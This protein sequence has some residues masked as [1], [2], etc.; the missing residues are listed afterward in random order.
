MRTFSHV[1]LVF[2]LFV[3]GAQGSWFQAPGPTERIPN[4]EFANY[5]PRWLGWTNPYVHY[6]IPAGESV[7]RQ[8]AFGC[9]GISVDVDSRGVVHMV[10]TTQIAM[11][12]EYPLTIPE[13]KNFH[14]AYKNTHH[15]SAV[16]GGVGAYTDLES[17]WATLTSNSEDEL[18][19][20]ADLCVDS[21]DRIH[22]VWV[23]SFRVSG[24]VGGSDSY[25]NYQIRYMRRD[26]NGWSSKVILTAGDV[27]ATKVT[28]A[29]PRIKV[30]T[31]GV[32]RVIAERQDMNIAEDTQ[33]IRLRSCSL[34]YIEYSGG[35]SLT[36]V[37]P[38]DRR[39]G[40]ANGE[41]RLALTSNNRPYVVWT[42][43]YR[44]PKFENSTEYVDFTQVY[45]AVLSGGG[46][47]QKVAL[48]A[49]V[50]A[51]G[52]SNFGAYVTVGPGDIPYFVYTRYSKPGD[53]SFLMYQKGEGF[54]QEALSPSVPSPLFG[55]G[56]VVV[57]SRN[58]PHVLW[59]EAEILM[60]KAQVKN[61]NPAL[62]SVWR[63][64]RPATGSPV[65]FK[66]PDQHI[67][68]VAISRNDEMHVAGRRYY[69]RTMEYG[70][71]DREDEVMTRAFPGGQVNLSSGNLFYELP[72]FST[73]GFGPS[74]NLSLIYNSLETQTSS[75]SPGWRFNL[76]V[77]LVDNWI[78]END[79]SILSAA[80]GPN[81]MITVFFGDGRPVQFRFKSFDPATATLRYLVADDEYGYFGKLE[82]TGFGNVLKEYKLTTKH[83]DIL[84][85]NW[86]GRLGRIEDA[87]GNYMDITYE[88]FSDDAGNSWYRMKQIDDQLGNG[89]GGRG[90]T[91]IEYESWTNALYPARPVRVI[92]P[93]GRTIKLNYIGAQLTSV[94]FDTVE[95]K[96][97]Y[98]FEYCTVDDP[99]TGQR[100]GQLRRF[101]PPRGSGS[102]G[103]T[104][105]YLPDGR[106]NKIEDPSEVLVTDGLADTAPPSAMIASMLVEYEETQPEFAPRR[107]FHTDRRG[108]KT[109]YTVEPRRSLTWKIEEPNP[110]FVTFRSF[111][112]YANLVQVTDRLGAVTKYTYQ[113]T[114]A[115]YP[116]V[117][118]NLLKIERQ[119][120]FA[121]GTEEV[122]N[123]TYTMD[124]FN[125]V[126]T[127]TTIS[128]NP[129]GGAATPRTSTHLYNGVGQRIHTDHPN[130][131]LPN[132]QSQSASTDYVYDGPRKQ[133][134]RI[135]N[136]EGHSTEFSEFDPSCGFPGS[137]LQEGGSEARKRGYDSL[138]N[139]FFMTEPRGG[140]KN[141]TP[142]S[143][144][145]VRDFKDRI[146]QV[147]D[148]S[149][150]ITKYQYD[151]DSNLVLEIPP[152]GGP[153]STTYDKRGYVSGGTNPDG[154][155]SEWVDAEGNPRRFRNL[156][157]FETNTDRDYLD[158]VTETRIPGGSTVSGGAGGGPAIHKVQYAHDLIQAGGHS[159]TVTMVGSPANRTS[160]TVYDRRG[161]QVAEIEAD[162]STQSQFFHNQQD[163]VIAQQIVAGGV[164]QECTAYFRD[165][166]DRIDH[167]R[168]QEGPYGGTI[169]QASH[170]YFIHNRCGSVL[171]EVDPLGSV[172]GASQ[173]HRTTHVYDARERA[174][175][176]IDG[177]GVIVRE[178]TYGDDD[179]VTREAGPDPATKGTELVTIAEYSY[180]PRK[181]VR[182]VQNRDGKG[183][184]YGYG[185][186][187]GQITVEIDPLGRGKTTVYDSF[188]QHVSEVI[189][190]DGT[191]DAQR[192]LYSWS[193]GLLVETR[194]W[195][196]VTHGF[197]VIHR[198]YYD[199]SNRL[200]REE[201]PGQAP[202]DF[203]YNDF[204]DVKDFKAGAKAVH[205]TY[206]DL[207]QAVQSNWS[208]AY[209]VQETRTFN[210]QGHLGSKSDGSRQRTMQYDTWKGTPAVETFAVGGSTWK[211]QT[212]NV[213]AAGN[214]TALTNPEGVAHTWPVDENNRPKEKRVGANASAL[215]TY[216]PGGLPD[217]TFLS[218]PTG[219]AVATTTFS[220]D[221]IG[222]KI[223]AFTTKA[224]TNEVVADYRWEYND[225]DEVVKTDYAHLGAGFD[226]TRDG[227]GRV[228]VEVTPGNGGGLTPPPYSNVLGGDPTGTAGPPSE[229]SRAVPKTVLPVPAR[230][231]VVQY[232]AAGNRSDET[233][234]GVTT[235]FTYNDAGQ[236]IKEISTGKTVD[237][238]YDD[239]GN[240]TVKRTTVGQNTTTEAYGYDPHGR[241]S[242]YTNSATGQA[243]QYDNWPTGERYAKTDLNTSQKSLQ[244]PRF[245][246]P[247]TDYSQTG[248]GPIS[249][250]N[251]YLQDSI[252]EDRAGRVPASGEAM[253]YLEGVEESITATVGSLGSTSEKVQDSYGETVAG[254]LGEPLGAAGWQDEPEIGATL[255]PDGALY[256]PERGVF[257]NNP[258][259]YAVKIADEMYELQAK[260]KREQYYS[261]KKQM[262]DA[263]W[264][265]GEAPECFIKIKEM[266]GWS[267]EDLSHTLDDMVANAVK[268]YAI[269][270][271][272]MVNPAAAIYKAVAGEDTRGNKLDWRERVLA[273]LDAVG[274][275]A[276]V[277][278]GASGLRSAFNTAKVAKGAKTAQ[279]ARGI[280]KN[281]SKAESLIAQCTKDCF[282]AGTQVVTETGLRNIEDIRPGDLVLSRNE[283]TGDLDYRPVRRTFV[284][285]ADTLYHVSYLLLQGTPSSHGLTA[286]SQTAS[287]HT[288]VCTSE[289][290]FWQAAESD[291]VPASQLM[292]GDILATPGASARIIAIRQERAPPGTE[293]TTFN[294]EVEGEH[295][296]FVT[297]D[298]A[299]DGNSAV[300]VHN[301]CKNRMGSNIP[302]V[303][304]AAARG[305]TFHAD[306]PGHLPDQIRGKYDATQFE[307]KPPGQPGQDV[308]VVGGKHPS[309]YPGSSWPKDKK[310][311]DFKP[312]TP[313]G[314]KTF[315]YDQK[316]K[317]KEPTHM[318]PYD[319]KTGKLVDE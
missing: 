198:R 134:T 253:H 99:A 273:G 51:L 174:I 111:D 227:Q 110:A 175:M 280:S 187:E 201:L 252:G 170:V 270:L 224:G 202:R 135:L 104:C 79:P 18:V 116:H 159:E 230:T 23:H 81:E 36:N 119:L 120:P 145:Y 33:G 6:G 20:G 2:L 271:H 57:D 127:E 222:R 200:E 261:L 229:E 297:S 214:V 169:G 217:Q 287:V 55:N 196:P 27:P 204:S 176:T 318:L 244:L 97:S 241:L 211:V 225:A 234:N 76:D 238:E 245:G 26:A 290:P 243:M 286:R 294:F 278:K 171:T 24:I 242:A 80:D 193:A 235:A 258:D 70:T 254:G 77:R 150:Y 301:A 256:V 50:S 255:T 247:E 160:T 183:T 309:K 133:L 251:T 3:G 291:W 121:A 88:V 218:S 164:V 283:D 205:H 317:W 216:T 42:E 192:T 68:S 219:A 29:R 167:V 107:T 61:P 268:E 166:R 46:F 212:H 45:W 41:P 4:S 231:I 156:R 157:G 276:P 129:D 122:A 11:A 312:D 17:T 86:T 191:S 168:Q 275:A 162:G 206:N 22:L 265:N 185:A 180:T 85:F 71:G 237:H 89:G 30:G 144:I 266:E 300:W 140:P 148:P 43:Q 308:K 147:V 128:S 213:D 264:W 274:Y 94:V 177:K 102:Y 305:S 78:A 67:N 56:A 220:Y 39:W 59:K 246:A 75:M 103:Y 114:G 215:M 259:D 310:F 221:G 40:I 143:T 236:L 277:F 58:Q 8:A 149:G 307:F 292:V 106:V 63:M 83:G 226:R 131:Q 9:D 12:G 306:R 62:A 132:G 269:D 125:R 48:G 60:H 228:R 34:L 124:G 69:T 15:D 105:Y 295:T 316:H 272:E 262:R 98:E 314:R 181:E 249:L 250:Q 100:N 281:L 189:D 173:A 302:K 190:G 65:P 146:V 152:A 197:D 184:T 37:I 91:I 233:L 239:W 139:L 158:R 195:S 95:G 109:I 16:A 279:L 136:E 142:G 298:G 288:V 19:S 87:L 35:I 123:Y 267:R 54:T 153:E 203:A 285:D 163:E 73:S 296:Y 313:G 64:Q 289:H 21:Q 141:D 263:S 113:L 126:A 25:D 154:N 194:T 232:D 209:N 5:Y 304:N 31:D 92:D 118:D 311:A 74:Q 210:G 240:R 10:A 188:T 14:I 223:R 82:R 90:S 315:K 186:K 182:R 1:V 49:A 303:R 38:E 151:V 112:Q 260:A 117:R 52:H 161:R 84:W 137:I 282:V 44:V 7:P 138:G 13:H 199:K 93:A 155:W 101:H 172:T 72:L 208:G 108:F 179:L 293:F 28:Y 284:Q 96:P 47:S 115:F 248:T 257:F 53:S 207:G 66:D 299:S 130:V 319:P 178:L 32:V 165:A